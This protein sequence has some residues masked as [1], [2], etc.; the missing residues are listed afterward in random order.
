MCIFV[1]FDIILFVCGKT[2]SL[3]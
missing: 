2:L 1:M 3:I